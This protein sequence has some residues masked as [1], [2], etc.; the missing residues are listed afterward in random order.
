MPVTS[1]N[2]TLIRGPI[3]G[4]LLWLALPNS[5]AMLASASVS[6]AET[7]YVALLGREALAA[8]A[9][10]FPFA[11][12][13]QTLSAGGIGGGI[14]AATSRAIGARDTVTIDAMAWHAIVIGLVAGLIFATTF[15]LAG[16]AIF[17][18]L[19]ARGLVLEE[20]LAFS[21]MLFAGA[22]AIWITNSLVSVLRGVGS[23]RLSSM[24]IA[25]VACG[26][27]VLGA[28]AGLGLGAFTVWGMAGV[29]LGSVVANGAAAATLAAYLYS[30]RTPVRARQ[31]GFVIRAGVMSRILRVGLLSCLS[32]LQTV[33]MVLA[34]SVLIGGMGVEALAGYGV[35]ARLEFVLI[36][37]AFGIGIASVP[38]VGTAIGRG[39]Y[40]RARRVAWTTG[41]VSAVVVG[42]IG[43]VVSL[44]PVVWTGLFRAE[45]SVLNYAA[46][47]LRWVGPSYFFFGL[48]M[49]LF[50]ASQGAGRVLGPVL[51]ATVRLVLVCVGGW[52]LTA[53]QAPAWTYF[54]LV[55]LAMVCYGLFT[56]MSLMLS[57]WRPHKISVDKGVA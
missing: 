22:P 14:A 51:A 27:I 26:Q 32:P 28:M 19:G 48:G 38:M 23:M 34:I 13:M 17:S 15:L 47:Y 36:P 37:I 49:A 8:I 21:N 50:F 35:A 31:H 40:R 30:G 1:Y 7:A 11:M 2:D 55:A 39:D 43:L 12:L 5:L 33:I 52:W 18:A 16:R 29:A 44:N 46:A 54:A 25:A 57:D 45:A 3:L 20:A 10:V 6:I 24:T 9:L 42:A 41:L 56:V 4:T 53:Q